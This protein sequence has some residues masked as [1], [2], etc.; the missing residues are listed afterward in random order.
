MPIFLGSGKGHSHWQNIK[1]IKQK[2]D[3]EKSQKINKFLY[4]SKFIC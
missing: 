4:V 3:I 2:N 1:D